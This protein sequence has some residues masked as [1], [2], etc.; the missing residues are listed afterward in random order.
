MMKRRKAKCE[1]KVWGLAYKPK[2]Q[3]AKIKTTYDGFLFTYSTRD[4]AREGAEYESI[5][6]PYKLFPVCLKLTAQEV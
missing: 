2:G 4:E 3:S 1:T 5:D 6:A